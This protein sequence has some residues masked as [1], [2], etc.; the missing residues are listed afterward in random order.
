MKDVAGNPEETGAPEAG[1]GENGGDE[2]SLEA[3]LEAGVECLATEL[4][5]AED[6]GADPDLMSGVETDFEQAAEALV[7]MKEARSKLQAR[8]ADQKGWHAIS[9]LGLN[10][11][12]NAKSYKTPQPRF[13][14]A[15]FPLRSSFEKLEISSQY[16]W[17]NLERAVEYP[18][19][20]N[21]HALI[22]KVVPVLVSVSS[23]S[24]H[25]I[26]AS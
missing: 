17:Y 5:E 12:Y 14:S 4:Q 18:L 2:L 13:S 10:V 3:Y 7:T 15:D 11:A 9:G 1:H 22:G 8:F 23:R 21:Q 26:R 19:L 6:H 16:T 20:P 24:Q 25:H